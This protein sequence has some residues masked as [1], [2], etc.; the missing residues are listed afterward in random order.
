MAFDVAVV[1]MV[2]RIYRQRLLDEQ[3][4]ESPTMRQCF[5]RSVI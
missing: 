4:I 1:D 2:E 5:S 3:T